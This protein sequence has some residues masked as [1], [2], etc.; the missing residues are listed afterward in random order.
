MRG[1]YSLP[2]SLP[3]FNM[4]KTLSLSGVDP[5]KVIVTVGSALKGDMTLLIVT[6][7]G[8]AFGSDFSTKLFKPDKFNV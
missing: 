2:A 5:F 3:F 4:N 7:F 6:I 8:T 1:Y